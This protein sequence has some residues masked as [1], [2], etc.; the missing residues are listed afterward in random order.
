MEPSY[1]YNALNQRIQT[2]VASAPRNIVFNAAGQRVTI[3][4]ANTGAQT[5]GQYYWGG[6]PVA[7]YSGGSAHFQHQDWLGTERLRTTYNGGVEGTFRSLPFGDGLTTIYSGTDTDAH[8]FA[9]VD[10]DYEDETDHAQFRQYSEAQWHWLAPDPYN[11]SYDAS[12]P[13]SFNRYAYA[14]NNPLSNIDPSGLYCDWDGGPPDDEP[15]DGGATYQDCVGQGGTWVDVTTV[16]V[17]AS[18]PA[19]DP[20]ITIEDGEQIYPVIINP[21]SGGGAPSN[22]GCQVGPLNLSQNIQVAKS[23]AGQFWSGL[24]DGASPGGAASAGAAAGTYVGLVQT[25][26]AWDPKNGPGGPTPANVAAG[27]INFGATCSQ[28]GFNT[29]LGGQVCQY[30]AGIYGKRTGNYGSP[31]FSPSHGDWPSD[32]QQIQQGLAIARKGGC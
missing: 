8:H 5:Q 20:G 32:N 15:V 9:T 31:L 14:L 3:W 25:G 29:W 12:N 23:L 11:G 13:Q 1:L 27:N 28:F 7:F 17:V 26:G 6:K 22:A 2:V 18:A 10:H 19:D 21:G 4:N 30:G 24:L 16:T